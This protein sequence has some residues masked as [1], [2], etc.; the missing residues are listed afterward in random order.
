MPS[1]GAR[2]AKELQVAK[3]AANAIRQSPKVSLVGMFRSAVPPL[4]FPPPTD[5]PPYVL[6]IRGGAALGMHYLVGHHIS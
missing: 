5:T 4:G 6:R 2:L 1:V 3:E